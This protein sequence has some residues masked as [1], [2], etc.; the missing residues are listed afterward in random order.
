MLQM[1]GDLV[2][3]SHSKNHSMS[4]S[5]HKATITLPLD[6]PTIVIEVDHFKQIEQRP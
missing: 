2:T 5:K 6:S 4:G 3:D 1:I